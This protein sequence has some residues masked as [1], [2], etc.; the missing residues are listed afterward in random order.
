[1][2]FLITPRWLSIIVVAALSVIALALV[3]GPVNVRGPLLV[4][5]FAAILAG[6]LLLIVVPRGLRELRLREAVGHRSE[7]PTGQHMGFLRRVAWWKLTWTLD[8][9]IAAADSQKFASDLMVYKREAREWPFGDPSTALHISD[10]GFSTSP[11]WW[12]NVPYKVTVTRW[13]K[14]SGVGSRCWLEIALAYDSGFEVL[15]LFATSLIAVGWLVA[16]AQGVDPAKSLIFAPLGF[17]PLAC[18]VCAGV[19]GRLW[20]R[21]RAY[22]LVDQLITD[23][24]ARADLRMGW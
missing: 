9:P 4:V 8:S 21:L 1:L 6:G 5:F 22:G 10:E 17:I 15:F 20:V 3:L 2:T 24:Q 23:L 16:L 12:W 7:M 19:I 14:S 13:C 18:V 11:G